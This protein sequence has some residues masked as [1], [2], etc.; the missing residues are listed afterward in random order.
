MDFTQQTITDFFR[1]VGQPSAGARLVDYLREENLMLTQMADAEEVF[2]PEK[3][4]DLN[5]KV[6]AETK[7]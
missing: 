7:K 2:D 6:E 1:K 5:D 4:S 3:F